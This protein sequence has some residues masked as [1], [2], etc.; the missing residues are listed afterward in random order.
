MRYK[1]TVVAVMIAAALFLGD[2]YL[3]MRQADHKTSVLRSNISAMSIQQLA[4]A[5]QECDS[6]QSPAGHAKYD[7]IYCAEVYRVIEAEPLQIV[8]VPPS[9]VK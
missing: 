5:S 3:R 9:P 6:A 8:T 4:R 2:G 7:A 1:A